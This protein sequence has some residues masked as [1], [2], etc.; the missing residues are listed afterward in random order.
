MTKANV[1]KVLDHRDA[2]YVGLI[3]ALSE[4]LKILLFNDHENC[5]FT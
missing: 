1:W 5:G 3:V 4:T 2:V